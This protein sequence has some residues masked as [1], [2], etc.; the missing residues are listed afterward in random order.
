MKKRK[1]K[2]NIRGISYLL[3]FIASFGLIIHD[4]YRLSLEPIFTG[5]LTTLTW[6]GS[7]T[8]LIAFLA[9]NLS[10]EELKK[11]VCRNALK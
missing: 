11:Y 5:K 9:L 10:Y 6:F 1:K 4:T 3:L 7:I 2:L 8:L